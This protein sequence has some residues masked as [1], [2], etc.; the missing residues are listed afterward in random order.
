MSGRTRQPEV[1]RTILTMEVE[2]FG[3]GRHDNRPVGDP[4]DGISV[5]RRHARKPLF[6]ESM[7]LAAPYRSAVSRT[8]LVSRARATSPPHLR[9]AQSL[10][11]CAISISAIS[12]GAGPLSPPLSRGWADRP[13]VVLLAVA[14]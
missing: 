11:A 5:A 12:R 9:T 10:S 3:D 14:E 6:A 1:R 2:R 13:G 8:R 7:R 4:G